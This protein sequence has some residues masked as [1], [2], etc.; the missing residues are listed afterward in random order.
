MKAELED[1]EKQERDFKEKEEELS[2]KDK[3]NAR[4]NQ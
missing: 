2:K 1:L 4:Y 3:V